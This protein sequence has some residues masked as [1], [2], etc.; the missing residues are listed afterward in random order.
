M[1]DGF[2]DDD[3]DDDNDDMGHGPFAWSVNRT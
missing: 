2:D 3:D 1:A